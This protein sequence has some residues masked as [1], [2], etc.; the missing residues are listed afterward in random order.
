[1]PNNPLLLMVQITC[2]DDHLDAFNTWYNSH[3]PNLLRIPG[4]TWAQRYINLEKSEPGATRFTALYGI[5][6]AE[7][8]PSLLDR[9]GSSEFHPIAA[10]EFGAFSQLD[11][12]SGHVANVYEQINGS[13]L[14]APLLESDRP[15]S[16]ITAGGDPE[17]ETEWDN[18]YTESH[19]PNLLKIPG[20]VMARRFRVLEHPALA[21]FNS[22]PKYLAIYEVENEDVLPTLRPGAAM[23]P[24]ARAELDRWVS[25]GGIHARDFGWG[26]YC[27]IQSTLSGRSDNP[28]L[29]QLSLMLI[30]PYARL[31]KSSQA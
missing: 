28:L 26:F 25:Y 5:R 12:I 4:L 27:L 17:H 14:R 13:P 1:M 31:L 20:Y 6:D 23:H 19:V 30:R 3:L 8:F 21:G 10:S 15:L 9:T 2:A 7:D 16:I 24:A 22:A 18:W 29:R 11:G